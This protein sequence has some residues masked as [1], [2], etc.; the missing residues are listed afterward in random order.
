[1]IIFSPFVKITVNGQVHDVGTVILV[2]NHYVVGIVLGI[3]G[4]LVA[5][6]VLA[7]VTMKHLR[8][9]KTGE[10]TESISLFRF[11]KKCLHLHHYLNSLHL[12]TDSLVESRL[13]HYSRNHSLQGNGSVELLPFGDYRRGETRGETGVN[14]GVKLF[15][16]VHII[17]FNDFR[18]S[19]ENFI[20]TVFNH[21]RHIHVIYMSYTTLQENITSVPTP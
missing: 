6:A 7:Y 5:G 12:L 3:L 10:E 18:A 19:Q 4:A 8:K 9:K 15:I 13:S 16:Y 14:A 17:R 1:M 21:T 20:Y 11:L 2:S